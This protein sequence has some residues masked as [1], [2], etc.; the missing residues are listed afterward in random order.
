MTWE[1]VA[2]SST[3]AAGL[4]AAADRFLLE[5]QRMR[6]YDWAVGGWLRLSDAKISDLP[7]AAARLAL[8]QTEA[9]S[10]SF[11]RTLL[12]TLPIS[13]ALTATAAVVGR[14]LRHAVQYPHNLPVT[15]EEQ[16]ALE[17][18]HYVS[19]MGVGYYV[20]ALLTNWLFDSLTLLVFFRLLRH[21]QHAERAGARVRAMLQGV[22]SAVALAFG[23][24]IC[25]HLATMAAHV[26]YY[27]HDIGAACVA[28]WH[29]LTF[30]VNTRD[31]AYYDDI[32]FAVSTL[33]PFAGFSAW[34]LVLLVAKG[35]V[36][37]VL[38]ASLHG[39]RLIAETHPAEVRS[40]LSPFLLVGTLFAILSV[41]SKAV[42]DIAKALSH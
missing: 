17:V 26:P 19:Y 15:L 27:D 31:A 9:F 39:L 18:H 28:L 34:L 4:G 21:I 36:S 32:G 5:S 37:A 35:L 41:I 29:F 6:I 24:L 23:C 11:L 42:V 25:A 7:R 14:M 20:P 10:S 3:A 38:G 30:Q 22:L 13:A 2:V 40:K 33:L 8:R 12:V 1:I 16:V